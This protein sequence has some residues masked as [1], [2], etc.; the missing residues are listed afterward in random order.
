MRV[1]EISRRNLLAAFGVTYAAPLF[2]RISKSAN[3]SIAVANPG[4]GRFKF[5]SPQIARLTACKVTSEDSGRACSIFELGAPPRFGPPRHVHHREDEWYYIWL[6][7][8][9]LKLVEDS[10]QLIAAQSVASSG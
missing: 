7:I 3:Q 6:A 5:A 10:V 2:A 1:T 4:E 9:F 8:S